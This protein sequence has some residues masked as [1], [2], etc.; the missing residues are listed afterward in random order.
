MQ[1]GG[2]ETVD[3]SERLLFMLRQRDKK[4][5]SK[6]SLNQN[7]DK[8]RIWAFHRKCNG[9]QMKKKMQKN[10]FKSSFSNYC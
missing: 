1:T 10:L 6:N 3:E 8:T 9:V 4:L 2:K 7:W 5:F